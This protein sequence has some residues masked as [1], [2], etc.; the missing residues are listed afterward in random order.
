VTC[1]EEADEEE[2]TRG[3]DKDCHSDVA[4]RRLVSPGDSKRPARFSWLAEAV[5]VVAEYDSGSETRSKSIRCTHVRYC[6]GPGM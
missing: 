4:T 1:D 5:K 3:R 2:V 6:L